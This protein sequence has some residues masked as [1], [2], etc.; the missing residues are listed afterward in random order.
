MQLGSSHIVPRLQLG[1]EDEVAATSPSRLGGV[2][3]LGEQR[4]CNSQ[5]RGS[6]PLASTIFLVLL[7][8]C[9]HLPPV[10]DGECPESHPIKGNADSGYYHRPQDPYYN[11]VKAE[12]CFKAPQD[13]KEAG[14]RRAHRRQ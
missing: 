4:V 5:V 2:A 3:Q 11:W 9:A 7:F 6:I 14:F 1:K 8:G 13:A 10:R 12:K